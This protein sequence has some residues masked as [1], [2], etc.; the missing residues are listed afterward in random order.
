MATGGRRLRVF[1]PDLLLCLLSARPNMLAEI[2]GR[3]NTSLVRSVARVIMG[4]EAVLNSVIDYLE[5]DW[6]PGQLTRCNT[7]C[8]AWH[9]SVLQER[10]VTFI[11]FSLVYCSQFDYIQWYGHSELFINT[12]LIR[13][14]STSTWA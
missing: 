1:S 13:A 9:N 3:L 4:R 11:S 14:Q 10:L 6:K 8:V 12:F 5:R 2:Y 7:S